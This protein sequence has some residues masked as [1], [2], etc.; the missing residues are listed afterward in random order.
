[1]KIKF[2]FVLVFLASFAFSQ[3]VI[4]NTSNS[5]NVEVRQKSKSLD[6]L[7][8]P[9]FEDFSVPVK[10]D[11]HFT[12]NDVTIENDACILPPSVGAAMFDAINSDG[13]FHSNVYNSSVKADV[14]TSKP[15]NLDY[16][17][18]S[19]IFF[20][21]YYQP[22][23]LLDLP[24]E[25]DSLV[26]QFFKPHPQEWETVWFATKPS[27][28]QPFVQ[29]ILKIDD[30]DFLKKGFK[31]RFYNY[32]SIPSNSHPTLVGNCD[33]WFVDYI[34]INKYRSLGDTIRR[35]LAFQYPL[36]FKIDDYQNVPY[37]HY[38]ENVSKNVFNH[39]FVLNLQNNENATRVIHS[40]SIVFEDKLNS[41]PNDTLF[42][43]SYSCLLYTSPSPRDRTR[44]RM[45]S[46]A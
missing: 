29:V 36:K 45:P 10:F 21:F 20:S 33:F 13:N 41:I 42:V 11:N 14:L 39:N 31:F 30:A 46:S 25:N 7:E 5:G 22:K 37:K 17:P 3:E 18:D 9:F 34:Y 8:L 40:L 23:G 16:H 26:L 12:D 35:D 27:D 1:M 43:G 19:N 24:E 44:S 2:V 6:T 15:I 4:V 28:N 32:V 38:K